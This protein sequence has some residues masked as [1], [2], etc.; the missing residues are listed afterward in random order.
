GPTNESYSGTAA[1]FCPT[2]EIRIVFNHRNA[3]NGSNAFLEDFIPEVNG[4]LDIPGVDYI[5]VPD[6]VGIA[7]I[8]RTGN[9]AGDVRFI[10]PPFAIAFNASGQMAYGDTNGRI[11]YDADGNG[12]YITADTRPAGY[13]PSAWSGRAGSNNEL[14]DAT[15]L[16][17]ELPFEAIPCV[18]GV[19]VYNSQDFADDFDFAG[20]GEVGLTSAAG[21]W[22]KENGRTLFFSPHTG[23]ALR[24]EQQE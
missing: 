10:A 23:I 20:G 21:E 18:P 1:L 16:V 9:G 4:Y 11:Y 24:D 19:V 13:N 7:G 5:L 2:G 22:L 12:R 17:R 14:P 8:E 3:R 6:R 15:T